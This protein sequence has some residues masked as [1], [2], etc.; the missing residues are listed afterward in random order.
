MLI[1]RRFL[2]AALLFYAGVAGAASSPLAPATRES[3][4]QE[5]G[6]PAELKKEA[7]SDRR[8]TKDAPLIVEMIPAR[9]RDETAQQQAAYEYEK[10]FNERLIAFGTVGLAIITAFLAWFTFR[11]WRATGKL[12]V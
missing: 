1:V 2:M 9:T 3:G 11:L 5:Q 6:Q 10:T 4:R 7:G 12:V 8:G